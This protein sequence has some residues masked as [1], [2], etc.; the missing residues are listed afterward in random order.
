MS[1]EI[2]DN[3]ESLIQ[4]ASSVLTSYRTLPINRRNK[5][6]HATKQQ[7]LTEI[8]ETY[9][10]LKSENTEGTKELLKELKS[11]INKSKKYLEQK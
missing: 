5:V 11:E 2:I 8:I 3:I 9:N 10:Q 6:V 7:K 4:E 1:A